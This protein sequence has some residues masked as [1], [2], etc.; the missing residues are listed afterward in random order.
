M[1]YRDVVWLILFSFCVCIF[2]S[3]ILSPMW[4]T[5]PVLFSFKP[6][7]LQTFENCI[8]LFSICIVIGFVFEIDM[9]LNFVMFVVIFHFFSYAFTLSTSLSVSYLSCSLSLS[10]FWMI[11]V[12]S[13]A[14][15]T[16]SLYGPAWGISLV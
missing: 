6:K 16:S 1:P 5:V 2:A 7:M 12:M 14:K 8:F 10:K 9:I 15:I 11:C 13:S 3:L 4:L